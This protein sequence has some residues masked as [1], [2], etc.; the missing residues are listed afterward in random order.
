MVLCSCI[1]EPSTA[2]RTRGSLVPKL[3][4]GMPPHPRNS[5]STLTPRVMPTADLLQRITTDPVVCH[6]QPCVH[7]LRYLVT[8][9][10]DLMSGG[11][12]HEEILADY[13]DLERDD[14]LAALAYAARLANVRRA[15][16]P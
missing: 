4:L 8:L 10:L 12:S 3:R 6:G 7:G 14:L 9:L 16:L 11:M 1:L 13:G 2:Q 5:L 15:A